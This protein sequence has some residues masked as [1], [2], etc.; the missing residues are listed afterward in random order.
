[1]AIILSAQSYTRGNRDN[2][3]CYLYPALRAIFIYVSFQRLAKKEAAVRP[4][5][6]N[7]SC[8]LLGVKKY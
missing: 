4:Q 3:F 8:E 2:S 7:Y 6:Y 5:L 1:M